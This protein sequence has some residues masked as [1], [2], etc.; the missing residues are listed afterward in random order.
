MNASRKRIFEKII[1]QMRDFGLTII[2]I[3]GNINSETR[4]NTRNERRVKL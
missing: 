4:I 1:A 2:K 3:N